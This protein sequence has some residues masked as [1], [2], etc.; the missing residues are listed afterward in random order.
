MPQLTDDAID[1]LKDLPELKSLELGSTGITDAGL[2]KLAGV[3]KMQT[4]GVGNTQ[5]TDAGLAHLRGFEDLR[6]LTLAGTNVTDEGLQH[7][8]GLKHLWSLSLNGT[9]VTKAGVE[10]LQAALPSCNIRWDATRTPAPRTPVP[11]RPTRPAIAEPADS[12]VQNV[13][14][15]ADLEK[16]IQ[17]AN[18]IRSI[19]VSM[20]MLTP[21][22]AKRLK[23]FPKSAT[24]LLQQFLHRR[25]GSGE[26]LRSPEPSSSVT[27]RFA[28]WR[29]GLGARR[30]AAET[31]A[32]GRYRRRR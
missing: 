23:E 21:E 25:L 20:G 11:G 31:T 22:G 8:R 15:D 7:L 24:A 30:Q 28:G 4:L 13:R 1:H 5:I 16:L 19:S 3:S 6:M 26:Y 18:E 27:R 9:S 17:R 29:C 14:S 10:E 2:A 32:V 12:G